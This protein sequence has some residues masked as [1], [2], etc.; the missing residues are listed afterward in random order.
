MLNVQGPCNSQMKLYI[1]GA[2][3][4]GREVYGWAKDCP[5]WG[6]DWEFAGFL[7]DGV[8]CGTPIAGDARVVGTILDYQPNGNELL[9]NGLGNPKHKRNVLPMLASRNG[10]FA[11]M[12]HPTAIIGQNVKLGIGAVICPY[13]VLTCDIVLGDF[14]SLNL[15]CSIGHDVVA[16]DFLH[17]NSY[18]EVNGCCRLENGVF[19][20]S[21]AFILQD[22]RVGNNSVVG[23]GS[24]VI[25]SIKENVTVFGNPA[26]PISN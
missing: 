14:C 25:K 15:H 24:V 23:A 21:H 17:M 4:F 1:I 6:L 19:L 13:C 9:L 10:R 7:D 22:K 3:G 2:G 5:E 20:G 8:E 16:G 26:C 18:S 11:A 12:I